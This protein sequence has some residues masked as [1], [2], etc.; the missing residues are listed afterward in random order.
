MNFFV[1]DTLNL[2]QEYKDLE[3]NLCR[4]RNTLYNTIR[5][6]RKYLPELLIPTDYD[7]MEVININKN[8]S[9]R[10]CIQYL[11]IVFQESADPEKM[12]EEMVRN[13]FFLRKHLF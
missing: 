11:M 10:Y 13:I 6:T 12:N 2:H 4:I 8:M 1:E 3:K 9:K 7:E 5:I